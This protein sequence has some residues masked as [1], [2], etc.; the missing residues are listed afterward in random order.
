MTSGS[1]KATEVF[2]PQ[3]HEDTKKHKE[4]RTGL[5]DCTKDIIGCAIEVHKRLGPG[6]LEKVYAECL[7]LEF[8]HQGIRFEREKPVSINYRDIIL[9]SPLKADFIVEDSCVLELKA[10]DLLLPVHQAQVLTYMKLCNLKYGLLLNF[11]VPV[12]KD[13]IKRFIL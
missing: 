10:V 9:P 12:L 8:L 1:A 3:R 6:L 2:L 5:K 7:N 13:G 4:V 11:N